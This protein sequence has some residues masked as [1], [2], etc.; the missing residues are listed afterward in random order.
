MENM[1]IEPFIKKI[2]PD[3]VESL[4]N[5]NPPGALDKY[6][7]MHNLQ[8]EGVAAI[9]NILTEKNF[10]YLADEVGMGKTYQ[11]IGLITLLW[12]LKRN[13]RIVV[14][15]PRVNLQIKWQRDYRNFIINNYR[16]HMKKQG[17]DIVKSVLLNKPVVNPRICHNLR[18]FALE[19]Q[20]PER[21]LCILRYS[22][23][24]RPVFLKREDERD[25]LGAWN[26]AVEMMKFY[27]IHPSHKDK[28]LVEG[29]GDGMSL[30]FNEW[31]AEAFNEMLVNAC[32]KEKGKKAIDLLIFDEGQYLRNENQTNSVIL[33][34]FEGR[35]NKWLFLSATPIHSGKENIQNV[36]NRY[37]CP[38]YIADSDLADTKKLQIKMKEF[39]VRRPREYF[40]RNST[41][42][43]KLW[44][45]YKYRYHN[46]EESKIKNMSPMESLVMAVVQKNL[47]KILGGKNNRFKIGCLTSF[48]SLQASV[49]NQENKKALACDDE[50]DDANEEAEIMKSSDLYVSQDDVKKGHAEDLKDIPD[51]KF[52]DGFA[53]RYKNTFGIEIPHPK[54]D[55]VVDQ[56]SKK[57]LNNGEKFVV[58]TRRINAVDEIVRRINDEYEKWIR[59]RI[60]SVWNI[61]IDALSKN[62]GTDPDEM[63]SDD[64]DSDGLEARG[65][66]LLQEANQKGNWLFR[67]RQTFRE[68]GRNAM[69]FEENWFRYFSEINNIPLKD[70][71]SKIPDELWN[72]SWVF[73]NRQK[74]AKTAKVIPSERFQYLLVQTVKKYP[75]ILG[76]KDGTVNKWQNF[77]SKRYP[78]VT[79]QHC[80]EKQRAKNE[81][82]IT[83]KG[84]WDII[85]EKISEPQGEVIKIFDLMRKSMDINDENDLLKREV[86]KNCLWQTIRLT[87]AILD[88]YC[89]NDTA[90]GASAP[91]E[92]AVNE[93]CKYLFGDSD[94]AKLLRNQMKEWVEHIGLILTNCFSNDDFDLAGYAAR[95]SYVELRNPQ[96][97]VGMTGGNP[98]KTALSQFKTP[99]YPRVIVCTDILKE[100]EDLHLFCDQ[101]IHYGVAW[102]SGD[103]EQRV[104]RIDRYFSMIE[105]KLYG[106]SKPEKEKLNIY[107]PHL[108]QS[109][110]KYQ[111]ER[112]IN[113]AKEA[114]LI[115]DNIGIDEHTEGRQIVLGVIANRP[116][117]VAFLNTKPVLGEHPFTPSFASIKSSGLPIFS[118]QDAKTTLKKYEN[119]FQNLGE[120]LEK[121]GYTL[122]CKGAGR[123][124]DPFKISNSS[125]N[126]V[127]ECKWEF[128]PQIS[129]YAIKLSKQ[130][131]IDELKAS[132]FPIAEHRE[133]HG[134]EYRY[135]RSHR[136]LIHEDAIIEDLSRRTFSAIRLLIDADH[137]SKW[138]E[139]TTEKLSK[140][141]VKDEHVVTEIDPHCIKV[142]FRF[143]TRKHTTKIKTFLDLIVVSSMVGEIKSL[144]ECPKFFDENGVW[145]DDVFNNWILDEN[146][147]L[148]FGYLM[149][150]DNELRFCDRLFPVG[151]EDALIHNIVEEIARTAD[152]YESHIIGEDIV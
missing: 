61:D 117:G 92:D 21:Q 32:E 8:K 106:S 91:V 46:E 109:V 129:S 144:K 13:A 56:V 121:Q 15:C 98:N 110:E 114:E 3:D 93:Y 149:R 151:L 135:F 20:S 1:I 34:A 111:I 66:G 10:A 84:F 115:M 133:L 17:D 130:I 16:G 62:Q 128:I 137:L 50:Q 101:I 100:G 9:Y 49:Y 65:K 48:E 95:E 70:I 68:S 73:A 54:V 36:I 40:V 26:N 113:R 123:F 147:R 90:G 124:E 150:K 51:M 132:K 30:Q 138:D 136:V 102:T 52:V 67:Y 33:K 75:E 89:A 31:F 39:L 105:R 104:G 112:V 88:L 140:Y 77:F 55:F 69:M 23:F 19:L 82:L 79:E 18:Q 11:A 64:P 35:V 72:E 152:V 107:Y 4:M 27:G 53:R 139:N 125:N 146:A 63:I 71:V 45:K 83:Y 103:L 57:A 119:I 2:L 141:F 74:G 97:A 12:N 81:N 80:G 148:K 60:N 134:K 29:C 41:D 7:S 59:E 142:A 58:F 22:S 96:F 47:V 5:F 131:K 24:T 43:D 94:Y 85:R 145:N 118:E 44:A 6:K 78:L 86:L 42:R 37:A 108:T 122:S 143:N 126:I 127:L 76:L 14:I 87:D 116:L 28:R 120:E 25:P 38:K 99:G